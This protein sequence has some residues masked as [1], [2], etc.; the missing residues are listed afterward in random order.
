LHAH[1]IKDHHFF[2]GKHP[3]RLDPELAIEVLG[4]EPGVDYK[5]KTVSEMVWEMSQS[6]S[7][8][9]K[10]KLQA[11]REHK[12]EP[13]VSEGG[14]FEAYLLPYSEWGSYKY[15]GLTNRQEIEKRGAEKNKTPEGIQKDIESYLSR[16][17][18]MRNFDGSPAKSR[19]DEPVW[20]SD[21]QQY[22]HIF[23]F[24]DLTDKDKSYKIGN[25]PITGEK[26]N[27]SEFA[28]FRIDQNIY[29]LL[30]DGDRVQDLK[31]DCILL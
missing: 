20:T 13:I 30:S 11:A 31:N 26:I 15:R 5:V 22:L 3:Y 23:K 29:P 9:D 18:G 24:A 27:Q 8:M 10:E 19:L 12:L 1:L 7:R 17:K 4:I 16:E 25:V 28:V 21:V 2:E 6:S 14:E